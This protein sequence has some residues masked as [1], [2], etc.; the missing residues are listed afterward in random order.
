MPKDTGEELIGDM[1]HVNKID[2]S[3]D[4]TPNELDCV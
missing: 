3:G 1:Q 2:P 4:M